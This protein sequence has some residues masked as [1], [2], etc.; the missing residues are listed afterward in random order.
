MHAQAVYLPDANAHAYLCLSA[1]EE[2]LRLIFMDRMAATELQNYYLQRQL[3][4]SLM[5]Q[6]H[7]FGGVSA[8]V[9]MPPQAVPMHSG[10]HVCTDVFGAPAMHRNSMLSAI[11][12]RW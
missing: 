3:A 7:Q 11:N 1:H 12:I 10:F 9:S 4:Q 5:E 8:A 6:M 2:N